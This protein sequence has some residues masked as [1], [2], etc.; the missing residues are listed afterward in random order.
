MLGIGPGEALLLLG[1]FAVPAGVV[2]LAVFLLIRRKNGP[3]PPDG[4]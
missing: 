2:A 4:R 1:C 3:P